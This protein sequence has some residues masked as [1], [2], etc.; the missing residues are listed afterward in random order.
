MTTSSVFSREETNTKS[1]HTV[2]TTLYISIIKNGHV[3]TPWVMACRRYYSKKSPRHSE[4]ENLDPAIQSRIRYTLRIAGI[5]CGGVL[6]SAGLFLLA[7]PFIKKKRLERMKQPGY[8]P[9][10]VPRYTPPYNSSSDTREPG[11]KP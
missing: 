10:A 8:K 2:L 4:F 5:W 1:E 9:S 6:L 7:K 11:K 3:Y